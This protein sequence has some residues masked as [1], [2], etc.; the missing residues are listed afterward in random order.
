M[1]QDSR[2]EKPRLYTEAELQAAIA[3][4]VT[5]AWRN[6]S[7]YAAYV[8]NNGDELVQ[9]LCEV[10]DDP[11]NVW[12]HVSIGDHAIGDRFVSLGFYTDGIPDEHNNVWSVA[13]YDMYHDRFTEARGFRVIG[14]QPLSP[15]ALSIPTD[16]MAALQAVISKAEKRGRD[17]ALE[18]ALAAVSEVFNGFQNRA[19]DAIKSIMEGNQLCE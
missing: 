5:G 1:T 12:D 8:D 10:V 18:E 2:A 11:N 17:A 3:A 16:A 6:P 19:S 14:W 15:V 9:V 4:V 13:G 7:E